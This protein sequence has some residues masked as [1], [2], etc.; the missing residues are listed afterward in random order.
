MKSKF[1]GLAVLILV[2][3]LSLDLGVTMFL[4]GCL[5]FLIFFQALLKLKGC[6]E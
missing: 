4:G 5:G 2:F 1:I 6:M 3:E